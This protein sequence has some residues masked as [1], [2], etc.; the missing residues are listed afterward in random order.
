MRETLLSWLGEDLTGLRLLDAGCGTGALAIE[1]AARGA[2][3]VAVD[4][5]HAGRLCP[6]ARRTAAGSSSMRATCSTPVWARFDHVVAMDSLIHYRADDMVGRC[7]PSSPP[8]TRGSI[9][10]TFAPRTPLL[11]AM[12]AA[13][14][15]FPRGDRSPAIQPISAP[16]LMRRIDAKFRGCQLATG[17]AAAGDE[18]VSTS[19]KPWSSADER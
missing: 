9:L 15:L 16:A 12:H 7:W 1:A 6:R 18:R 4:I 2:E 11:T 3:V 10:F 13:G 5:S 19:P 8:A 14:K 17:T